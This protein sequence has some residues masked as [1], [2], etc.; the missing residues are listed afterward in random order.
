MRLFF[1]GIRKLRRRTATIVA[2]LLTMGLIAGF[3]ALFGVSYQQMKALPSSSGAEA[4]TILQL[5][6]F[7]GAYDYILA[8]ELV[9]GGLVIVIFGAAVGGSEWGW[10]TLKS[11]VT[12]GE[13]RA[14]YVALNFAAVAAIV[15]L[16]TVLAFFA[17]IL[18]AIAGAG[19][20]GLSTNGIGDTAML[21]TLPEKLVRVIIGMIEFAALGYSIATIS[22]SQ[23]A[24]VG[25]S[26]G[27]YLTT[28]FGAVA[29]PDILR[30]FPFSVA[31]AGANLGAAAEQNG[32]SSSQAVDPNVALLVVFAWLL[33]SL[34]VAALFT[35]RAEIAG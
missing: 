8:L 16:T 31:A 22:R 28:S 21:G 33:G 24:G 30:W 25:A 13:S 27:A 15:A 19:I 7:P 9:Y 11:A 12:R 4:D 20:A 32:G 3:F 2:V 26:I 14:R 18:G 17:G 10:G 1:A 6:R 5:L 34:A 35:E 23:L 29:I